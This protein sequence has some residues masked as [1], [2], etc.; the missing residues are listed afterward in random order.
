MAAQ[1]YGIFNKHC[2]SVLTGGGPAI[3]HVVCAV[4]GGFGAIQAVS[5]FAYLVWIAVI[6]LQGIC[7]EHCVSVLAGSDPAIRDM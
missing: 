1:V 4:M 2:T 3:S 6:P 5:L 7:N